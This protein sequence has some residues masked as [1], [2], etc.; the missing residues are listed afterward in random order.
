M[1]QYE[2][3]KILSH[4]HECLNERCAMCGKPIWWVMAENREYHYCVKCK[5]VKSYIE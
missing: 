2:D 4:Q 3:L 1:M 5:V